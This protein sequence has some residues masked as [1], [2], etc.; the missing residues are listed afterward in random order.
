MFTLLNMIVYQCNLSFALFFFWSGGGGAG[1]VKLF[2][3]CTV[4]HWKALIADNGYTSVIGKIISIE[5]LLR[6]KETNFHD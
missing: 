2:S 1:G 5:H 3:E 6:Q 4:A